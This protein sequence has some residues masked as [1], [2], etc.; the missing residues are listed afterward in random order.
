VQNIF[1]SLKQG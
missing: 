1:S